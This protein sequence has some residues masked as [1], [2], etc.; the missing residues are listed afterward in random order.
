MRTRKQRVVPEEADAGASGGPGKPRLRKRFE[1][2]GTRR[3]LSLLRPALSAH[4][5]RRIPSAQAP[6]PASWRPC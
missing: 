4:A 2:S 5:P 1:E 3:R 6:L